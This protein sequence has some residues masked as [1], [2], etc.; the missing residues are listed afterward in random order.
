MKKIFT[1]FASLFLTLALFAATPR[2]TTSITI[3]SADRNDIRVVIDGRRFE[4]NDN[5]MRIR[6]IQ[7][8]YHQLKIYRE[9]NSGRFT[10]FGQRYDMVYNS[11]LYVRPQSNLMINIDMYGRAQVI[12][13]RSRNRNNDWDNSWGNQNGRDFDYDNGRNSGDYGD[14]DRNGN[15]NDGRW[16]NQDRNGGWDRGNG[17]YGNGSYNNAMNDYDFS[18][19]LNSLNM[20]RDQFRKIDAAK[21]IISTNFFTSVQV[22]QMLQSFSFENDKLDLAKMAYDKTVDKQ[23]FYMV[24]DAFQ[25]SSSKDELARY[26]RSH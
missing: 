2:P 16:G 21:Q 13:N 12:E 23:N 8:G 3:Q 1:I 15:N 11:S 7:P 24:N 14:R 5:F 4:P 26:I 10:I 6:G 17:G 22:R 9:R 25:Y 18:R 19:A 20:Q